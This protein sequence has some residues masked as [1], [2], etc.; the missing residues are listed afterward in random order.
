MNRQASI[1]KG[2]VL[3]GYHLACWTLAGCDIFGLSWDPGIGYP[4]GHLLESPASEERRDS[5]TQSRDRKQRVAFNGSQLPVA[6]GK[7][8]KRGRRDVMRSHDKG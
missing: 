6:E 7:K 5:F 3:V 1:P 2:G 8:K 4:A